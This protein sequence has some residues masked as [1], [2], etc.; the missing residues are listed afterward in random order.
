MKASEFRFGSKAETLSRLASVDSGFVVPP[1]VSFTFAEWNAAKSKCLDRVT[2]K[3]FPS[4]KHVAVRS[5]A[6][7]EDSAASAHAGEFKSVLNVS[8][9]DTDSLSSAVDLVFAS[10]SADDRHQVLIQEMVREIDVAGVILTRNADDGAPYYVLN[11]DDLSGR[12]DTVTG[13][14]G[15]HKTVYLHRDVTADHISSARVLTMVRLAREVEIYCGD[16][17]LDMEFGIGKCGT[18]YLFQV[19]RLATQSGWRPELHKLVDDSLPHLST[20]IEQLS[21]QKS[22]LFGDYTILANMPDWNPAEIIGATPR[23]F[24]ISL[25]RELI[26]RSIWREA[27]A[28]MGYQPLRSHELMIMLH[29]RPYIDVRVSLNSFIPKG[30]STSGSRALVEASLDLLHENPQ[31]HDKLEFEIIPTVLDCS[32]DDEIPR[33]FGNTFGSS[34]APELRD[35][36]GALTKCLIRCD[37][38]SSLVLAEKAVQELQHRQ[39]K[40]L[41]LEPASPC[42]KLL[43]AKNL[44]DEGAHLGTKPFATLARHGFAGE[45]ILRSLVSRGGL[46]PD[47]LTQFKR[48]I[49]TILSELSDATN[50]V[51]EGRLS[52]TGFFARFGHLR[53]GTYDILSARY[54]QRE[55]FFDDCVLTTEPTVEPFSLTPKE[56]QTIHR[57]LDE[58]GLGLID[59]NGL[60]EYYRRG[61]VGREFGKFVFTRNLSDAMELI[62]NWGEELGLQRDTLSYLSLNEIFE[63]AHLDAPEETRDRLIQL[64]ALERKETEIS[65]VLKLSYIIRDARDLFIVPTHRSMTNFVTNGVVEG[66]TIELNAAE[67]KCSNLKG[68]IVC[69]ENADPGFDWIFTRGLAGLVTKFGGVNSHMAIRCA[70]VGLPAAIGCGEQTFDDVICAQSVAL[71]CADETVIVIQ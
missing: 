69:I 34:G 68:S 16:I 42:E 46:T 45:A 24:A 53:P 66:P 56:I 19:R 71:N 49:R 57:L 55:D 40:R 50:W 14:I 3:L 10:Y 33:R 43:W 62:A 52:K 54:D 25:Y 31:F 60:L 7:G 6:I 41:S 64:A 38:R 28:E 4:V 9:D 21:S 18:V 32:F 67:N 48:S 35:A 20:K 39:A 65:Q 11:Y 47:R 51:I 44:L 12:T 61:V 58:A 36:L 5:S 2:R 15:V 70:E 27:R 59:A 8:L 13:G 30:L 37:S 23:P 22:D 26:T 1:L 29:R 63:A 17:P